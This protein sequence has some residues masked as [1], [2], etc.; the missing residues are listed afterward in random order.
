MSIGSTFVYLQKIAANL[1]FP[2]ECI[3]CGKEGNW[4]C[5][6]CIT[7]VPY[8]TNRVC[9]YCF[10]SSPTG[11]YCSTCKKTSALERL[12]IVLPY[13]FPTV[14]D[15]IHTLKYQG[16]TSLSATLHVLMESSLKEYRRRV[17]S[18]A[19]IV[20]PIPL[21][22]RRQRERGFNQA[23]ILAQI[24]ASCLN[25]RYAP[26]ILQRVRKTESQALLSR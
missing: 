23:D 7:H 21:H 13:R 26:R 4:L 12:W 15:L 1:L 22:A 3:A 9:P 16:A 18:V 20:I 10:T 17:S 14:H 8:W 24:S 25:T 11:I 19:E 6:T 2:I 5:G